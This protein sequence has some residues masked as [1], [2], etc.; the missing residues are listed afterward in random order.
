MGDSLFI[1]TFAAGASG[2]Y[3]P[4]AAIKGALRTGMVAEAVD[5]LV[6]DTR[7]RRERPTGEEAKLLHIAGKQWRNGSKGLGWRRCRDWSAAWT[8]P[9]SPSTAARCWPATP[10]SRRR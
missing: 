4:A 1:P 8:G 10:R 6:G 2:P 5:R 3:L 9:L 7:C